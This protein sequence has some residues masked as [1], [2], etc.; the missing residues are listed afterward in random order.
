MKVFASGAVLF[1]KIDSD[2]IVGV[3]PWMILDSKQGVR[4]FG[5]RVGKDHLFLIPKWKFFLCFEV[6]LKQI[7]DCLGFSLLSRLLF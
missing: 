4:F 7:D 6:Y 1:S 3:F 5:V 2:A